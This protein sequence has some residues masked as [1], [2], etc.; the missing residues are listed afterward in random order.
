MSQRIPCPGCGRMLI[1]PGAAR[2]SST[3]CPRCLAAVPIP[4]TPR[5]PDAVQAERPRRGKRHDV[6]ALRPGRGSG[7][8][9]VS[10]V[11]GTLAR[12]GRRPP[13]PARPR[14]APGHKADQRGADCAG[15]RR[16]VGRGAAGLA[17]LRLVHERAGV[18][19]D[20]LFR[21]SACSFSR[22]SARLSCI[23]DREATPA[24]AACGGWSSAHSPW[25]AASCSSAYVRGW[26]CSYFSWPSASAATGRDSDAAPLPAVRR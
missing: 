13:R 12:P 26:R 23:C 25:R 7:L 8:G 2:G 5:E 20:A 15:R 14:R 3:A 22:A 16:G 19:A 18:P 17:G 6:S 4:E 21:R 10:V 1:A 9:V 24:P 11:R